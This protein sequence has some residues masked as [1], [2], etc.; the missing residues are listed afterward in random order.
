MYFV[1]IVK[2]KDETFYTGICT[3][4]VRRILEHNTGKYKRAY[5]K[6]RAPVKLVYWE[7]ST[8]RSSASKREIEIKGWGR[9]KKDKLIKS[10]RKV[11]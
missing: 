2:C 11:D 5:T 10:L 9:F 1:Y 6:G 7:T 8:D 3:D 4:L